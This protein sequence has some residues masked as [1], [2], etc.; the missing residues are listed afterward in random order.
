MIKN[1]MPGNRC[2]MEK[3]IIGVWESREV[4]GDTPERKVQRQ[5]ERGRDKAGVPFSCLGQLTHLVAS[6][7]DV[8]G[9]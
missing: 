7:Y 3:F 8:T 4:R 5:Q 9:C 1:V 6:T 2:D